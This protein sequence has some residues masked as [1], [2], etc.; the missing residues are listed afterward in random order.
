MDER[1]P[2]SLGPRQ[3]RYWGTPALQ[4]EGVP[5]ADHSGWRARPAKVCPAALCAKPLGW[6]PGGW[7]AKNMSFMIQLIRFSGWFFAMVLAVA[8]VSA[9]SKIKIVLVGDLTVTATRRPWDK[10]HPGKIKSCLAPYAEE[11]RKIRAPKIL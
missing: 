2:Q 7:L 1:L 10:D 9:E 4:R 6:R 11:I 5:L 8:T 3:I